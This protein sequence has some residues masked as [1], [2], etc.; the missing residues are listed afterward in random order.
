[1]LRM[2]LPPFALPPSMLGCALPPSMLV[3]AR[4]SHGWGTRSPVPCTSVKKVVDALQPLSEVR[5][6]S[7]PF[8]MASACGAVVGLTSSSNV[9]ITNWGVF[10]GARP[11]G[12]WRNAF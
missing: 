9:S 5:R 12:G 4:L 11:P 6:S 1:M 10:A 3:G 7:A 2:H 8:R